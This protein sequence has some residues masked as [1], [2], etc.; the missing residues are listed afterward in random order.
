MF[1]SGRQI[2][3]YFTLTLLMH[4]SNE[5]LNVLVT[6]KSVT[7]TQITSVCFSLKK[8]FVKM[9]KKTSTN[10]IHLYLLNKC[11]KFFFTFILVDDK[12]HSISSRLVTLKSIFLI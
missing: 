6:S 8:I 1:S 7:H 11:I 12:V 10:I 9:Q 4:S 5:K 3:I 2:Q